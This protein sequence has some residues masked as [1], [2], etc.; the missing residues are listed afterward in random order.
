[1]SKLWKISM[2]GLLVMSSVVTYT[3]MSPAASLSTSP[4]PGGTWVSPT[5]APFISGLTIDGVSCGS[6]NCVAIGYPCGPAGCGGALKGQ[7]LVSADN[8]K[9]WKSAAEPA[10][11]TN[12]SSVGCFKNYCLAIASKN[13][14]AVLLRSSNGG[15]SWVV[16]PGPAAN[17]REVYCNNTGQCWVGG[18]EGM[19]SV[20]AMTPNVGLSWTL[21]NTPS[22]LAQIYKL[23]CSSSTNCI[24]IG[25]TNVPSP[26]SYAT[27]NAGVTWIKIPATS[28]FD[29]YTGLDCGSPLHCIALQHGQTYITTNGGI[30]W[31]T[32][33]GP[34]G[35]LMAVSCYDSL[36]CFAGGGTEPTPIGGPALM[37]YSADGGIS[38]TKQSTPIKG[39]AQIAALYC[40]SNLCVAGGDGHILSE[41]PFL[42]SDPLAPA[43]QGLPISAPG[44]VGQIS[45]A[46]IELPAAGYTYNPSDYS[47][48]VSWH[49]PKKTGNA[50]ITLYSVDLCNTTNI[51]QCANAGNFCIT[52]SK[53]PECSGSLGGT[54]RN[55]TAYGASAKY[56]QYVTL[57]SQGLNPVLSNLFVM[58]DVSNRA[59]TSSERYSH[60]FSFPS[61]PC[62]QSANSPGCIEWYFPATAPSTS[63]PRALEIQNLLTDMTLGEL[64]NL[65]SSSGSLATLLNQQVSDPTLYSCLRNFNISFTSLARSN[66][67]VQEI[68]SYLDPLS[69]ANWDGGAA[70]SE[71]NSAISSI[72]TKWVLTPN[73]TLRDA[74]ASFLADNVETKAMQA[75]L[76]RVI[77][78]FVGAGE[79]VLNQTIASQAWV[80]LEDGLMNNNPNLCSFKSTYN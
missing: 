49:A 18:Y 28:A 20:M 25:Y 16:A 2:V 46:K 54:I 3:T 26:L 74:L 77:G 13:N 68:M 9:T 1:M 47:L 21:W 53:W 69:G 57:S 6:T 56:S 7:I 15:A 39:D 70:N 30:T 41:T 37:F 12:E 64:S 52:S 24:I 50:P 32:R 55:Y 8:A 60:K 67:F 45:V 4:T 22:P 75:A 40:R 42:L 29:F 23:S 71:L 11:I 34:D 58:V 17:W 76:G 31:N 27:V 43:Q 48:Q 72:A 80:D 35:T 62:D 38:W 73:G 51:S 5:S 36:H 44:R 63:D 59:G 65:P 61:T 33:P 66:N 19:K 14:T 79:T 78:A 10:N